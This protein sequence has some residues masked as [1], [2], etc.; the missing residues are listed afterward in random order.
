M[1][2]ALRPRHAAGAD[3]RDLRHQ[4][5]RHQ[6]DSSDQCDDARPQQGVAEEPRGLGARTGHASIQATASMAKERTRSVRTA[7][8]IVAIARTATTSV[9]TVEKLGMGLPSSLR[10]AAVRDG[11]PQE[12]ATA[13]SLVAIRP[14]QEDPQDGAGDPGRPPATPVTAGCS[15]C[16]RSGVDRACRCSSGSRSGSG[17]PGRGPL[18]GGG[19]RRSLAGAVAF[20][21]A[22]RPGRSW[23]SP[24]VW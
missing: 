16:S 17:T 5:G 10:S 15:R 4:V 8:S 7:A 9:A 14:S 2:P 12:A 22:G 18:R 13:R 3:H 21:V 23:R 20:L 19:P 24:Q 1:R 6:R 11:R